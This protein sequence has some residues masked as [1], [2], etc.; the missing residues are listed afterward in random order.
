M[1]DRKIQND[2]K[3][4]SLTTWH[5]TILLSNSMRLGLMR[6]NEC[7]AKTSDA[8]GQ[9]AVEVCFKT[10]VS[11]RSWQFPGILPRLLIHLHKSLVLFSPLK[12]IAVSQHFSTMSCYIS[13][14]VSC[15]VTLGVWFFFNL[16]KY[17]SHYNLG[18]HN[19]LFSG[20]LQSN[21]A[22]QTF[23]RQHLQQ[24]KMCRRN[25]NYIATQWAQAGFLWSWISP[26]MT[27]LTQYIYILVF[28][29]TGCQSKEGNLGVNSRSGK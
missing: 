1:K 22:P 11:T 7:S 6:K 10:H 26:H 4:L 15:A 13:V 5:I 8:R 18:W 25:N 20:W 16:P 2:V 12:I 27:P 9:T 14:P 19:L 17:I 24:H 3:H 28:L 21:A 23:L 29:S